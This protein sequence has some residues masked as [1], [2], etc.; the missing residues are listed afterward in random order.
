MLTG[1]IP[2]LP[3]FFKNDYSYDP[4]TMHGHIDWLLASGV[5]G[6]FILSGVG[7]F[8]HLK[9][10]ERRDIA[11]DVI[12]HV[13]G[14]VPVLVGTGSSST[15][16]AV[17]LTQ[18][19]AGAGATAVAVLTP[20][21]WHLEE[22]QLMGHYANVANAIDV[23]LLIYNLPGMTGVNIRT[24]V[25]VR[26]MAEQDNI[27]GLIDVTD[28]VSQIR[29][30]VDRLKEV[31]PDSILLGGRAEHLLD[32]LLL[33]GAGVTS[34][35]ANLSAR[36]SV[37]LFDAFQRHDW[38]AIVHEQGLLLRMAGL[39][40]IRGAPSSILKEAMVALGLIESATSRPPA[41]PLNVEGRKQV[42]QFVDD[43]R[44]LLADEPGALQNP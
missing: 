8:L 28:S 43:L 5:H 36:P 29:Q 25:V 31:Q 17:E 7:E 40:S 4:A 22:D 37:A 10:G 32:L 12:K 18:H 24:D 27:K 16:E 23:P 35:T 11:A 9:T 26:L 34:G 3:T 41:F 21:A 19:A 1:V 39:D 33:G 44:A 2:A 14:R 13:A 15:L 20:T 38:E 6:L 42:R 30:R